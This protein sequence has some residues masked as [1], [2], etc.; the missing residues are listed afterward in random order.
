MRKSAAFLI[1]FSTLPILLLLEGWGTPSPKAAVTNGMLYDQRVGFLKAAPIASYDE[2]NTSASVSG[3]EE[4]VVESSGNTTSA[5][6]LGIPRGECAGAYNVTWR[7]ADLNPLARHY[8]ENHVVLAVVSTEQGSFRLIDQALRTWLAHFPP[9]NL[10]FVTDSPSEAGDRPGT[11]VAG[12]ADVSQQKQYEVRVLDAL[13]YAMQ[14]APDLRPDIRWVAVVSDDVFVN[15]NELVIRLHL[16]DL[17]NVFYAENPRHICFPSRLA[18][19]WAKHCF[20]ERGTL[21]NDTCPCSSFALSMCSFTKHVQA[22]T[23]AAR[24]RYVPLLKMCRTAFA[25]AASH[26]ETGYPK[27]RVAALKSLWEASLR[28]VSAPWVQKGWQPPSYVGCLSCAT[29]NA[30]FFSVAARDEVLGCASRECRERVV[31]RNET[32]AQATHNFVFRPFSTL[33]RGH[34]FTCADGVPTGQ[35]L[36]ENPGSTASCLGK[37]ER[38][39]LLTGAMVSV[40]ME[41][42]PPL[43]LLTSGAAEQ[44]AA[45]YYQLLYQNNTAAL[46]SLAVERRGCKTTSPASTAN[47]TF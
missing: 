37:S 20:G 12:G 34:I 29:T 16:K 41:P 25:A 5:P 9:A 45:L 14:A 35:S 22:E 38:N 3:G 15:L 10:I 31:K 43:P 1:V 23:G 19:A 17:R 6:G 21:R 28:L 18:T 2:N 36:T 40:V 42:A 30:H 24:K 13:S 27:A 26:A 11:W 47:Q 4:A 33:S 46:S 8:L 39:R 32:A 44:R 7:D